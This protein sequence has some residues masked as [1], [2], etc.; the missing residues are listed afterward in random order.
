M[1]YDIFSDPEAL[2][3]EQKRER[4]VM[5]VQERFGNNSLLRGYSLTSDGTLRERNGMIGGHRA[6]YGDATAGGGT[7]SSVRRR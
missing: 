6:G 5:A 3:R 7:L 4:T 1:G 2:E